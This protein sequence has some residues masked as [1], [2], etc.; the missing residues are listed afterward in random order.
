MVPLVLLLLVLLLQVTLSPLTKLVWHWWPHTLSG[1]LSIQLSI[2]ILH[3][4]GWSPHQVSLGPS[5]RNG[6]YKRNL[7][8]QRGLW[9]IC[10]TSS[11]LV[12]Y[13]QSNN[14]V[15][16]LSNLASMLNHMAN[17][18]PYAALVLIGKMEWPNATLVL[19]PIMLAPCCSMPWTYGPR[20]SQP[21]FRHSQ[22]N[23]LFSSTT[24]PIAGC[25]NKCPYELFTG[26]MPP[27]H[28]SDFCVFGHTVYILEKN[29]TDSNSIPKWKAQSYC[30]VYIGHSEHHA[31][32]VMVMWNP[33]TKLVSPQYHVIF[34]EEFTTVS[35][36]AQANHECL[37][38]SF[39][40]LLSTCTW[41]HTDQFATTTE[42]DT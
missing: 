28:L 29:L 24:W 16:V 27:H 33:V 31:S 35:P 8:I 40:E 32:N 17:A 4:L 6:H 12:K 26:E 5:S 2:Q 7:A 18:I 37:N 22:L 14:G 13:I 20:S 41:W 3:A 10:N 30:S 34:N 19:S 39:K 1:W 11:C 15:L 38:I 36:A 42:H 21:F 23:M 9:I 25:N